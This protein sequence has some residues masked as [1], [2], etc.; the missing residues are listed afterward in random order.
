MW[1]NRS[2]GAA[3]EDRKR[4]SCRKQMLGICCSSFPLFLVQREVTKK[5]KLETSFFILSASVIALNW[6]VT[7]EALHCHVR[8]DSECHAQANRVLEG[9]SSRPQ[10]HGPFL[11]CEYQLTRLFYLSFFFSASCLETAGGN[12]LLFLLFLSCHCTFNTCVPSSSVYSSRVLFPACLLLNNCLQ[13]L[14]FE[15]NY[16]ASNI[17]NL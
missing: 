17:I 6:G 4:R 2:N 12:L 16:T 13:P 9:N 8:S 3:K 15:P 5:G 1:L 11:Y 7:G 14:M 10:S